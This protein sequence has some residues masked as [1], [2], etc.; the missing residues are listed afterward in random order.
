M[1]SNE[2]LTSVPVLAARWDEVQAESRAYIASL[3]DADLA[4]V[5]PQRSGGALSVWQILLNT[6]THNAQHRAEVAQ[7]LTEYGCSPG[8]IDYLFFALDNPF[9]E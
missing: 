9:P 4:R 3:A 8:D 1:L 5:V 7:I 6:H 2:R